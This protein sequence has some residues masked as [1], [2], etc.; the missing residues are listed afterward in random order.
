MRQR[1][2]RTMPPPPPP[3]PPAPPPPASLPSRPVKTAAPA[4]GG[5][6]DRSALLKS[7]QKGAQLKKTVTNDR[8]APITGTVKNSNNAAASAGS[9]QSSGGSGSGGFSGPLPGIGGLFAGGMPTLKKTSGGINTGRAPGIF[10]EI[11]F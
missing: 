4:G 6:G 10:I 3:G 11:F 8:S 1:E 5:G 2:I 9:S 7:I